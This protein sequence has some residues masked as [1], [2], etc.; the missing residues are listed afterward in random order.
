MRREEMRA[1]PLELIGADRG[2]DRIAGPRE[3]GVEEGVGERP[4]GQS[5]GLGRVPQARAV[6]GDDDRRDQLVRAAAQRLQLLTRSGKR[7]RLVVKLALAG[8]RGIA[9][10]P[11]R[12]RAAA[13]R[14]A[15]P[16][17]RRASWR[18]PAPWRVRPARL[19]F[20]SSSSTPDGSIAKSRPTFVSIWRRE[21]LAE[22]RMSI[23]PDQAGSMRNKPPASVWVTRYRSPSGPCRT[24]RI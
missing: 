1:Q 3:I 16:S 18:C 10:R 21:G 24:S 15:A 6:P 14:R 13:S 11:R 23:G 8:E 9:R 22:A 20:T 17:S 2:A 5:A 7:G 12:R 19:S 4:H